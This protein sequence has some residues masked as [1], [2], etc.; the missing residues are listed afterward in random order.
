MKQFKILFFFVLI[1]LIFIVQLHTLQVSSFYIPNM[2]LIL[3]VYHLLYEYYLPKLFYIAFFIELLNF[4]SSG[5][6]GTTILI[7][8]PLSTLAHKTYEHLYEK[9]LAPFI[10]IA[11][12]QV[13]LQSFIGL[14]ST[15]FQ[16]TELLSII[17]INCSFF[18]LTY[19]LLPSSK[20][21]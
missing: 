14:H 20:N 15:T 19:F 4:I 21:E 17:I 16:P 12:Y 11:V 6:Y 18:L 8:T 10:F 3:Y 13:A 2:L 1:F 7:L 5:I 9:I